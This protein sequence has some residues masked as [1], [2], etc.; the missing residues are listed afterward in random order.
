MIDDVYFYLF[1]IFMMIVTLIYLHNLIIE[2]WDGLDLCK[3]IFSLINF[4]LS[5]FVWSINILLLLTFT[6][7]LIGV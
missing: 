5:I 2:N 3:D 1:S 6:A 7:K 4:L